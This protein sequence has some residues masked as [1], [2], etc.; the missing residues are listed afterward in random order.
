MS[1]PKPIVAVIVLNYNGTA[2]VKRCLGSIFR[3]SYLSFEVLFIDNNSTDGNAEMA[4]SLFHSEPYFTLIRNRKNFG[5][6]VG[7]NIGFEWTN[8]KYIF[9]ASL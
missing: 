5:F 4:V 3:N 6:S 9:A 7:N 2:Y 8:A 1:E